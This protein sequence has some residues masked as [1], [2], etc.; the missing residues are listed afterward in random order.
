MR[1]MMFSNSNAAGIE[2]SIGGSI[3]TR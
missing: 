2:H 3:P 1:N